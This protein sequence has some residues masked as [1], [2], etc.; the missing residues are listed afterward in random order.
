[1]TNF[2]ALIDRAIAR[3][4]RTKL[5]AFLTIFEHVEFGRSRKL[6]PEEVALVLCGMIAFS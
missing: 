5:T 4:T 2:A 1:M 6:E 3:D